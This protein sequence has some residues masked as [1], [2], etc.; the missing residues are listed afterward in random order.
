MIY[1]TLDTN[2]LIYTVEESWRESNSLDFIEQWI[3]NG[4]ITLLLPEVI[5]QEWERNKKNE[6]D[7][8]KKRLNEFFEFA[9][10]VLPSAFFTKYKNQ[11]SQE[12]IIDSQ[13]QRIEKLLSGCKRIPLYDEVKQ[14]VIQNGI[15]RKA[16][17]H[18]K[19]SI[20]DAVIVFSLIE[21]AKKNINN[22]YFFISNNTRDFFNEDKES[23]HNDLIRDFESYNITAYTKIWEL[24]A[25]L[26]DR[27][28]LPQPI[29]IE[30]YRK[31]RIKKEI[32]K[33]PYNPELVQVVENYHKDSFTQDS[34]T[35]DYIIKQEVP[36]LNQAIFVLALIEIDSDHEK[37]FY[38]N[39]KNKNW[40]SIL[41]RRK[42]FDSK[43]I[44]L[45]R[46]T[47]FGTKFEPWLPLKYLLALSK[48]AKENNDLELSKKVVSVITNIAEQNITNP[49]VINE[50]LEIIVNL[51]NITIPNEI[52]H[53]TNKWFSLPYNNLSLSRIFCE[54]LLP[55]FITDAPTND[56]IIKFH[57]IFHK[58]FE[59]K[60]NQYPNGID[61]FE[62]IIDMQYLVKVAT[63][64]ITIKSKIAPYLSS[65]DITKI[66]ETIKTLSYNYPNGKT[67]R[68][69]EEIYLHLT[70]ASDNFTIVLL[71]TSNTPPIEETYDL[72][73]I[74]R[75]QTG[76]SLLS[77]LSKHNIVC[78]QDI[79]REIVDYIFEG[80]PTFINYERVSTLLDY[81]TYN[82]Y[83]LYF[84]ILD[85]LLNA[86]IE[87]NYQLVKHTI[88][89][90]LYDTKYRLP[91]FKKTALHIIGKNWEYLRDVFWKYLESDMAS[92]IWNMTFFKHDLY[93]LLHKNQSL[94]KTNEVQI[95]EKIITNGP[96][97]SKEAL[98]T[99][100]IEN[101]QLRWY[102]ALKD[103]PDFQSKYKLVSQKLNKDDSIFEH[104]KTV[105]TEWIIEKTPKSS[106]EILALDTDAII[107]LLQSHQKAPQ[108]SY[109]GL[110][111]EL[112][113]AVEKQP[114][115]FSSDI[116]YY[117][118][119]N[120]VYIN[121]ITLGFEESLKKN[122]ILE[123]NNILPFYK[124]LIESDN[125]YKNNE[126]E[127]T[128]FI[129]LTIAKLLSVGMKSNRKSLEQQLVPLVKGILFKLFEL[130]IQQTD[131]VDKIFDF[132]SYLLNSTIG[133]VILSLIDYSLL[134]AQIASTNQA[135]RWE[136]DIRQ[137][138]DLCIE[139][140]VIDIY[141]TLGMY[142][143]D[144]Y[145]L[146][147]EW[148]THTIRSFII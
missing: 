137:K 124:R 7:K 118:D 14:R 3:S 107:E 130:S 23:I 143:K 102:S 25:I 146:D 99:S 62:S 2:I 29:E 45:P 12:V 128:R 20:G 26:K 129:Y 36:T 10:N 125:H 55:K 59:I 56:D 96:Q 16:P 117:K 58:L 51:P 76:Q 68:I 18:S 138:F 33:I 30:E 41:E 78:D 86:A 134:S 52:F 106:Y 79:L 116:D 90:F 103:I 101:W 34:L 70:I 112:K 54:E 17:S 72:A 100:H 109:Q 132:H 35:I 47:Q 122:N 98:D 65:D 83:Y 11:D 9:N 104:V 140:R 148:T 94:L 67:F 144:I 85:E 127:S 32:S 147:Q 131:S 142:F 42:V 4:S 119:L 22:D 135:I 114:E 133:V 95:L 121:S 44:P 6:F 81:A 46:E 93:D 63:D 97:N 145:Y 89:S 28:N 136:D 13:L 120:I 113:E 82:I 126:Q 8:Q 19:G 91:I 38:K 49:I 105:S 92:D 71:N 5:L 53:H 39:L 141:V 73:D 74:D 88:T 40:F 115:K 66:T 108:S 110:A 27:Y 37:S 1:L 21:Y 80:R 24:I 139:K 31:N 123:W 50:I 77:T 61:D 15:E 64:N 57:T 69:S 75:D 60:E 43:N 48:I 87:T 111:L 84:A